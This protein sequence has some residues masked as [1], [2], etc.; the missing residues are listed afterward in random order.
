MKRPWIG[1]AALLAAA[2]LTGCG[3]SPGPA[4]Y[5][6]SN[7]TQVLLIEWNTPANGQASGE[8]TYDSISTGG[9]D[10]SAPD[11]LS[12]QSDPVN[13]T[14]NGSQVTMAGFLSESITG[15]LSGGTLSITAPPDTSTGQ[16]TTSTLDASNAASYNTAVATL[17]KTI[18]ADNTQAAAAQAQAQQQQA[19]SQAQQKASS[20]LA[21]LQQADDF[22]SDLSTLQ[23]D[24]NQTNSD[25]AQEQSDA[26][27]GVN[28]PG[29]P[30]CYNLEDNVDYDAQENVAYDADEDFGYDLSN[31]LEADIATARSDIQTVKGDLAT[32]QQDGVSDPPG[33][34]A[35]IASA[36]KAISNAISTANGYISTV[37][38]DVAQ[39]YSIANGMATS[40]CNGPGPPP[41]PISSI[42]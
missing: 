11:T 24:L 17:N 10:A 35:A 12:V 28:G 16:I 6:A 38:G 31:D 34:S 30:Q 33:A 3:S 25:L 32:L 23:G 29:G 40:Q 1:L 4:Y 27:A 9:S 39:A 5:L 26:Q 37:N 41:T 36:R 19:D 42:T 20:D 22:Q 21:S 14:I 7:S 18:S 15:T 8:I 13:V 2:G